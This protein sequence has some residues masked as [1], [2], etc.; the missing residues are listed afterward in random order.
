MEYT[1]IVKRS[2]EWWNSIVARL[3]PLQ[4]TTTARKKS[5]WHEAD[6]THQHRHSDPQ[7]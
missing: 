5:P 3:A 7:A 2:G 4:V 1:A 6:P